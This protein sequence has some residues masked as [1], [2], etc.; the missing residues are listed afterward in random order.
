MY[1]KKAPCTIILATVNILVFLVLSFMGMTEDA[2]FMLEHG[3]MYTPDIIYAGKYYELFTCMFLHFG[4][5]HLMNNMLALTLMG[6]QLEQELGKIKFLLLYLLSGLAGN[7]CPWRWGCVPR[8]IMYRRELLVQSLVLSADC[9][10]L[11]SAI[12]DG[13]A[14]Y[15]GKEFYF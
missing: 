12:M 7:L 9:F 10:I 2:E 6:R 5:T 1:Q 3:A 13:L 14:I 4:F 8:N 11:P 15:Q